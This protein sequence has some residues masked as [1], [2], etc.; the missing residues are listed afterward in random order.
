MTVYTC[1]PDG[2][3]V[4]VAEVPALGV[5]AIVGLQ[6]YVPPDGTPV[7]TSTDDWPVQRFVSADAIVTV[8]AEL[9]ISTIESTEV[10]PV[11]LSVTVRR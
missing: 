5:M 1:V 6:L 4:S 9:I 8:A 2:D 7:A 3:T 11:I 10:Q